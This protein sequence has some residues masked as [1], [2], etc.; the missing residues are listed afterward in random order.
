MCTTGLLSLP[1]FHKLVDM[2]QPLK[3][4]FYSDERRVPITLDT[5]ILRHPS[6]LSGV[7]A[8]PSY[9]K[10]LEPALAIMNT[11]AETHDN[12]YK[13]FFDFEIAKLKRFQQYIAAGPNPQEQLNIQQVRKD[14]ISYVDEY[15]KRRNKNFRK[16]F[17]ELEDFYNTCK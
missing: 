13:G 5:A 2:I 8:D 15:D 10:M 6:Y 9:A 14:F 7:V 17:P 16:T 1:N 11:N 3:R 4:E 12:A